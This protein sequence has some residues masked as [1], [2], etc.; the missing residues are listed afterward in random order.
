MR[1]L[2]VQN[3]ARAV[4]RSALLAV[5]EAPALKR[6]GCRNMAAMTGYASAVPTPFRGGGIDEKAFAGFCDWQIGQGI[7]ALV[8][9]GTTGE[10]PTLS[11]A[12]L[13]RL[14]RV[15]VETAA[16]R[17]PVIAGAGSNATAH[18]IDLATEAET[19]GADGLLIVTP[20]YNRPSQE[21]LYRHFRAVHNASGLPILLYDVP[22]R[23]GC[24]FDIDT[25]L[26]L[27][28]LPRIVGLKDATGDLSRVAP[29][30][31]RL[32]DE[33]R[34]LAGNDA[35][36]LDFR[37]LGGDGCISVLS[38]LVPA[39]CVES[40]AAFAAGDAGAARAMAARLAPLISALF[41]DS[42]PVPVKYALQLMGRMAATVRMPLCEAAPKARTAVTEAL[43]DLGLISPLQATDPPGQGGYPPGVI[44][45]GLAVSGIAQEIRQEI[46]GHGLTGG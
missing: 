8:V 27:S 33:F 41:S 9:A 24:S 25:I 42:N 20:Y 23:T 45:I 14:I 40:D 4:S 5:K 11:K 46:R 10:A 13:G 43:T 32:G 38:N 3:P 7:A 6:G 18:A 21:G 26:R 34:L 16:G 12:E 44:P 28:E 15:A 17:V 2:S 29:L 31:R 37:A 30:R 39:S 19:Q 1:G 35:T 22:S 36:A